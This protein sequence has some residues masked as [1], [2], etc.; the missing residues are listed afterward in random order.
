MTAGGW[1][2]LLGDEGSG[3]WICIEMF[4]RITKEYDEGL[5]LS[6]LSHKILEKLQLKEVDELKQ[7]I[8]H[9]TKGEIASH[10]PF[11]VENARMGDLTALDLLEKAGQLLAKTTI[12]AIKKLGLEDKPR[13][14]IKGS[15]LVQIPFVQN[16]FI[17]VLKERHP[18]VEFFINDVSSTYGGYLLAKNELNNRVEN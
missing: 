9:A 15:I 1:G 4:K 8:Y 6:Y 17:Q 10:V 18:A 14:A 13:V 7:Y 16:A 3:Y 5:P 2:H 11:V 12:Q